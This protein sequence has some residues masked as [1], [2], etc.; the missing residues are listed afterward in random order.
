ML[1]LS[2]NIQESI[3]QLH[4]FKLADHMLHIEGIGILT[5]Q[6]AK[7]YSD[8]DYKLIIKSQSNEFV[9][10]LAKA[11][12]PDLTETYSFHPSI[13]YD[14][15]WFAT[16]GYKGVDISDVPPGSYELLLKIKINGFDKTFVLTSQ[17]PIHFEHEIV[18]FDFS[19][20]GNQLVIKQYLKNANL[21]TAD[22]FYVPKKFKSEKIKVNGYYQDEFN[23]I[24]E[25]TSELNNVQVQFFGKNNRVVLHSHSALKNT[26]IEFKGDNGTFSIGE[27]AG[28]FGTFRVGHDCNIKIGNGVTS[29]N[30]VYVTCAEKTNIYIGNDCM[31]ATNNQIRT[32]DSHGIYDLNTGKRINPSK[33]IF[34]GDHVWLAYGATVL[35]GAH[36]GNG[37]VLG[38]FSLVK[39]HFPENCILAGVPA[40]IIREN[41]FWKRP[42]LLNKAYSSA[43]IEFPDY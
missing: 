25:A 23:N 39:K 14:K 1:N 40:K 29:T 35:G 33:D 24:I 17:K 9:K 7:E 5:G 31:L 41:V 22:V 36:I 19:E 3:V 21:G 43:D 10:N 26:L 34:I 4:S 8:I 18:D 28:I 27:K 16:P 20:K 32:D 38:A 6:S 13:S 37:C 15:C 42:L 2:G 12:R 30:A 11:H